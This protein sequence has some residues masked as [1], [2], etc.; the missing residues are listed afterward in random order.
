MVVKYIYYNDN[1]VFY[2]IFLVGKPCFIWNKALD[3]DCNILLALRRN[4]L[5]IKKEKFY[6]RM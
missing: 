2:G 1:E 3:F 5:F 6:V 4:F